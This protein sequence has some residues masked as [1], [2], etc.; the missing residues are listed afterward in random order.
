MIVPSTPSEAQVDWMDQDDARQTIES[1]IAKRRENFA[2]SYLSWTPDGYTLK[3]RQG[4]VDVVRTR[5][6]AAVLADDT[7]LGGLL[8]EVR[9]GLAALNSSPGD[10]V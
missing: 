3:F 9:R 6:N 7:R 4:I 5:I 2:L 1:A 10:L 8:D